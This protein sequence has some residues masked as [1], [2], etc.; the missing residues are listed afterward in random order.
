MWSTLRSVTFR[1]KVIQTVLR[2]IWQ[3]LSPLL[4]DF[5]GAIS[6]VNSVEVVPLSMSDL[7]VVPNM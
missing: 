1:Y 6:K 5:A 4:K 7:S 3:V 2:A